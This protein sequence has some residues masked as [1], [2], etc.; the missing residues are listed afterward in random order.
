M[1]RLFL[2]T[3]VLL[4]FAGVGIGLWQTMQ[5]EKQPNTRRFFD[6]PAAL[7]QLKGAPPELAR[8]HEYS[9]KLIPADQANFQAILRALRGYPVVINKWTSWCGPCRA[10]MP[11]FQA[12]ATRWGS[13][14]AFIGLSADK[15]KLAAK[16]LLARF[17]LPYPSFHDRSGQISTNLGMGQYFP[18]TI[19][20]DRNG[21]TKSIHHGGFHSEAELAREIRLLK[22]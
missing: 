20:I 22:G 11:Y 2:G 3:A 16:S 14:I 5:P 9:S 8:L 7:E 1:R 12:A 17:P 19:F 6:L 15:G 21:K 4:I 13:E 10:E 18:V